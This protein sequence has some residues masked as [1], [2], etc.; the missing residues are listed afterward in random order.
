MYVKFTT[1]EKENIFKAKRKLSKYTKRI[2]TKMSL[3]GCFAK[4]N[5][6]HL[7]QQNDNN[8]NS[9]QNLTYIS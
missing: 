7:P 8:N 3:C 2:Q 1:K 9:L 5:E 4:T 6:S